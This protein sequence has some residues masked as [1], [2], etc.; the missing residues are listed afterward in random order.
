MAMLV[1]LG[2]IAFGY[3]LMLLWNWLVP[4][5][6]HGPVIHFWQAVGLLVLSKMLFGGFRFKGRHRCGCHGYG[7]HGYWKQKLEEKMANMTPEEKEKFKQEFA[8][9]CGSWKYKMEF[10]GEGNK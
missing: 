4:A 6:F 5:L 2:V 3:L 9:R 8:N 1:A 7:K 10:S